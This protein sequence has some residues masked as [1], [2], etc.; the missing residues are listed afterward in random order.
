MAQGMDIL[1]VKRVNSI[2]QELRD[3]REL[4]QTLVWSNRT[5]FV[6]AEDGEI[7]ARFTGNVLAADIIG[8]GQKAVV[9]S[10][11]KYT[12]ETLKIPNFKHGEAF[13]QAK[14]NLLNRIAGGF[15]SGQDLGLFSDWKMRSIDGLRLG[16]AQRIEA[17][18]TAC[19]I[20]A[21][22]YDRLGI[23]ITGATW[24]MPSDL[25]PTVSPLWTSPTTAKPIDN[26]LALK[27]LATEKY[28]ETYNRITM[29]SADFRLLIATA[30]F[31]AKAQL[32]SALT[33]PAATFPSNDLAS[34][35]AL[36]ERI[37]GMTIEFT[38]WKYWEESE[39]GVNTASPY[40][41]L[42]KVILSDS[43]DDNTENRM[44]FANGVVTESLVSAL[45]D[46]GAGII[47]SFD[48][49]EYGPV[50]YATAEH[51]PPALTNWG[52]A[53]GWARKKRQSSTAVLT[54]R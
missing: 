43:N 38:D 8:D 16:V 2:M 52:V 26:I 53:R 24:G 54:V 22:D 4:P 41:P 35:Q 31:T 34:M 21:Y 36:A 20:D 23:K 1:A 14:L 12:L 27:Q 15:A 29:P 17:V 3:V 28:G 45:A 47:G 32:Y 50:A 13:D 18:L 44:D 33:F 7:M 40:H 19:M 39:S 51:N 37:L 42:G 46:G 10:T 30:E 49:P 9:R 6:N 11:G 48:G 25:K 5:P